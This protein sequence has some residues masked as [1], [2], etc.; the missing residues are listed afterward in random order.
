MHITQNKIGEKKKFKKTITHTRTDAPFVLLY[1]M[2]VFDGTLPFLIVHTWAAVY[3]TYYA[4]AV[5][6]YIYVM[7]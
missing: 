7:Y 4:M 6:M 1:F 3:T 5:Q 2:L